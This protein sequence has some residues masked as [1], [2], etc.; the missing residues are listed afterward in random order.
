MSHAAVRTH[1]PSLPSQ[2]V[3]G[4]RIPRRRLSK[5]L[6]PSLPSTL[7]SI[8]QKLGSLAAVN[9]FRNFPKTWIP[10]RRLNI[11]SHAAVKTWYPPQPS[12]HGIPRRRQYMVSHA[13]VD[14][15]N[16]TPQSTLET[17][18]LDER[19][20]NLIKRNRDGVGYY[21]Y[22]LIHNINRLPQQ[23]RCAAYMFSEDSQL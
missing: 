8:F 17:P 2:R 22:V 13:A 20:T 9:T 15:W 5:N 7:F 3:S 4:T 16:P 11:E 12:I 18:T 6:G 10:R 14:T 19:I 21:K 1:S 23:S